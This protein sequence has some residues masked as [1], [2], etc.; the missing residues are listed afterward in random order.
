MD[1]RQGEE[2]LGPAVDRDHINNGR[3][4]VIPKLDLLISMTTYV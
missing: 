2:R 1:G 3:D 4:R